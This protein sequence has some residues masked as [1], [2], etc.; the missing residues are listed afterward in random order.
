[1]GSSADM[2]AEAGERSLENRL[3]HDDSSQQ[4]CAWQSSE[5]FFDCQEGLGGHDL[6]PGQP[7]TVEAYLDRK[8]PLLDFSTLSACLL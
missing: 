7:Y 6:L 8:F 3:D 2:L 5:A 4:H 1:M